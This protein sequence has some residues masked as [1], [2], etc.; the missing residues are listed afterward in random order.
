MDMVREAIEQRAGETLITEHA[1][2]FVE[3]QVRGDDRGSAFVTA[4]EDFEQQFGAGLRQRNVAEFVDDEQF[5]RVQLRL[6][7]QKAFLVARFHEL[8]NQRRRRGED[9]R[10]AS[11]AGGEPERQSDM[12]L[13][14]AA[15]SSD[16]LPGITATVSGL[17]IRFIRAAG[18]LCAVSNPKCNRAA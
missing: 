14:R 2:P 9:D 1:R 12:R 11:L 5:G 18:K 10:E 16:I 7:P 3:G 15:R 17:I 4:A 6:K 8:M 13:A